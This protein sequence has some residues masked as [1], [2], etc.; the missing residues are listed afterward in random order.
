MDTDG[1]IYQNIHRVNGYLYAHAVLC[2]TNRSQPLLTSVERF[3]KELGFQPRRRRYQVSL[4]RRKEI[5]RYFEVIG[6]SNSKH[7]TRFLNLAMFK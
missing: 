2:F 7:S 4:Y 3:L 1:S 5:V 6:T